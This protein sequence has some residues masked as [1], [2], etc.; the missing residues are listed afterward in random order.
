MSAAIDAGDRRLLIGAGLILA[1]VL[2][3][4]ALTQPV[5]QP[6]NHGFPS[7]YSTGWDGAKAAYLLLQ[8]LGYTVERWAQ[9]P[10]LLPP[11]GQGNVLILADPMMAAGLEEASAI[12]RFIGSGGTVIATGSRGAELIPGGAAFP[13]V[14]VLAAPKP[15]PAV[16][17]SSLTRDATEITMA[18]PAV[19]QSQSAEPVA[20]YSGFSEPVVLT[21]RYGA[22]RVIWW[23]AATPLTNSQIRAKGNLAFFLNCF[24]PPGSQRILWD[25]YYHGDRGTLFSY[26]AKTPLPWA[27]LQTA[28]LFLAIV[29]TFSRRTGPVR[30]QA[31]VARLSPLEFVETLGDLYQSAHA[32]SAAVNTA[33]QRFRYV[34]GRRTGLPARARIPDVCRAAEAQLGW[35][36]PALLDTLLRSERAMRSLN[37]PESEALDLTQRLHDYTERIAGPNP[38]MA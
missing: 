12:H 33:Y 4:G 19:W 22:G 20:L 23:A 15:Y 26:F 6:E 3:V 34:F 35:T 21:Y 30:A 16:A 29:F 9:P 8:D 5:L 36:E 7:S 32:G 38:G 18:N 13:G 17:P 27:G 2:V 11:I 28:I 24:G 31:A 1:A 10:D 37:V 25:E 14:D